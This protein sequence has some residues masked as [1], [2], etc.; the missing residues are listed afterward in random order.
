MI[1]RLLWWL[2][3]LAAG[4]RCFAANYP[5][6]SGASTATIQSTFNTAAAASGGNTV[7][8]AAGAYSITSQLSVPCPAGSL[9]ITGPVVP[10][11]GPPPFASPPFQ[12][13]LNSSV[14][15]TWMM[16]L[17]SSG[18]T[19]A[20]TITNLNLNGGNPSPDGGGI[21]YFPTSGGR[22]IT[23]TNNYL[24]G[25][26]ANYCGTDPVACPTATIP[27]NYD[28]LIWMD[29]GP[30]GNTWTNV[31]INWNGFGSA[32][33]CSSIMSQFSYQGTA[34][35]G[36]VGFAPRLECTPIQATSCWRITASTTGAGIQVLRREQH[37][38]FYACGA[39]NTPACFTVQYNDFSNIHRNPIEGQMVNMTISGNSTHD[40]FAPGYASWG[41]SLPQ[42]NCNIVTNNVRSQNLTSANY[43]PG[44]QEY[45]GSC[46]SSTT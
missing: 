3:I 6:S 1:R 16:T 42:L 22:N 37:P 11:P 45:W 2:V 15:G 13:T 44:S 33:D 39:S 40:A 29:G 20:I 24:Y 12:S 41:F 21:L 17:P 35:N 8:F 34:Y 32:N 46:N 38:P 27:K 26:S 36:A 7:T 31:T 18:C 4:Q 30:G 28:S 9:V 10:Y 23:V 5:I 43:W 25:N 14:T 19:G